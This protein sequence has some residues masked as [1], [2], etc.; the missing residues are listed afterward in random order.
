MASSSSRYAA[1]RVGAA[2]VEPSSPRSSSALSRF[3]CSGASSTVAV[4]FDRS[5]VSQ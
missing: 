1:S 4:S 2:V 5:P 3:M